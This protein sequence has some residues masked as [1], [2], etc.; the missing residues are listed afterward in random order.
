MESN[1]SSSRFQY[2][3]EDS[4][5]ELPNGIHLAIRRVNPLKSSDELPVLV[6]LHEGL[7]CIRM[8]KKFPE[9]LVAATGCPGL[10]YDREGYGGS[11]PLRE[12]RA[13]DYMHRAAFEEL[14]AVLEACG[15]SNPL[16][17]G[18]S[19][20]GT[21]ALL[22]ASRFPVRAIITVAAH[23]FVEGEAALG[24]IRKIVKLWNMGKVESALYRYH[25]EK[26]RDVFFAWADTWTAPW[27]RD[28]NIKEYLPDISCPALLIQGAKDEYATNDHLYNIAERLGGPVKT[29]LIPE[30]GHSPH[31]E[32]REAVLTLMRDFI[33]ELC[34]NS[35]LIL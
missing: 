9:Q 15:V 31:L 29:A 21:I 26:T 30:C 22:Y 18:H 5:I 17:V 12:V 2:S 10:I 13:S 35:D 25:G 24:G 4:T 3:V 28:W 14:P 19:D 23:I 27:F 1:R 34:R 20:G 16:L 8:W 11:D 33:I 7:G 32:H 6:F